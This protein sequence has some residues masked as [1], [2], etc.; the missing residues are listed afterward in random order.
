MGMLKQLVGLTGALPVSGEDSPQTT[1]KRYLHPQELH[2]VFLIAL[3]MELVR[4]SKHARSM[5]WA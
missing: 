3:Q 5:L 4:V 2:Q 1:L